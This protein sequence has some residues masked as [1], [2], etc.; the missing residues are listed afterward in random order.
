MIAGH[1]AAGGAADD[2][3]LAGAGRKRTTFRAFA[4]RIEAAHGI[5]SGW[6]EMLTNE[7]IVCRCEE[8]SYGTLCSTADSTHSSSLRALKLSTRAGLGICQG[9]I[10]GRT[11]ETLLGARTGGL[12]D[13]VS[14]DRRPIASPI[15][16]GELAAGASDADPA[17]NSTTELPDSHEAP[18]KG[19]K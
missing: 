1:V 5:R 13:G 6:P 2:R 4:R 16:L 11:V 9:R 8:V 18:M 7:T 17:M 10:C 14:T 15:R 19:P 12:T 3:D